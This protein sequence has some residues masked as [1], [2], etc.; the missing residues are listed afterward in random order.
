MWKTYI[1]LI[2]LLICGLEAVGQGN[3]Q[4]DQ[5]S[6]VL[7][8]PPNSVANI[9]GNEPIGQSFTPSL[10]AVGFVQFELYDGQPGNGQGATLYVNLRSDSMTGAVLATSNPVFMPETPTGGG[11]TN[12]FFSGP[13]AVTSGTTYFFEIVV[14]SGDFWRVDR[15]G[16]FY[17][18]GTMFSRGV[19]QHRDLWFREGIVVPEPS[20]AALLLTAGSLFLYLFR[21][22][23]GKITGAGSNLD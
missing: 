15:V 21:R 22:K 1:P 7:P 4:Y 6:A 3:F 14:Q 2:V 11:L 16:D 19:D 23:D 20:V 18:G 10:S 9:Q 13:A 17:S 12:F 5:Q 8:Q